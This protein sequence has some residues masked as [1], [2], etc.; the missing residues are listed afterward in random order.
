M[1]NTWGNEINI[2]NQENLFLQNRYK[3]VREHINDLNYFFKKVKF[4]RVGHVYIS[5]CPFD[6]HKEK[7]ASF[8]LYPKGYING[9]GEQQKYISFY[10]F[11]CGNGGDIIKFHQIYN[12]IETREEACQ[13]LE[14]EYGMD[15]D[16][17][18]IRQEILK[19]NLECIKMNNS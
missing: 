8:V 7:T 11:G 12:K 15:I 19:E 13:K 9:D 3:Y 14:E 6:F 18:D 2:K 17:K 10:C 16:S 5:L 4:K 1:M